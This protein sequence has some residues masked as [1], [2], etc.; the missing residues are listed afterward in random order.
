[1]GNGLSNS[2]LIQTANNTAILR[3]TTDS[4]LGWTIAGLSFQWTTQQTSSN[5]A[6]IAIEFALG[7][8]T[9]YG[10]YNG[11]IRDCRFLYGYRGIAITTSGGVFLPVWETLFD[12][13]WF[14][15][16]AGAAI[17]LVP[18]GNGG[19][20]N[21][22]FRHI[23]VENVSVACA[24]AQVD[25]KSQTGC[26]M[27]SIDLEG[28]TIATASV[29]KLVSSTVSIQNLRIENVNITQ[30]SPTLIYVSDNPVS[31]HGLQ[32][33]SATNTI[34]LV[35]GKFAIV[36]AD[37]NAQVTLSGVNVAATTNGAGVLIK[38]T[39]GAQARILGGIQLGASILPYDNATYAGSAQA[40]RTDKIKSVQSITGWGAIATGGGFAG[41]N[42]TVTGARVGDNVQATATLAT[43]LPFGALVWPLVTGN[44]TIR[45]TIF[46]FGSM[47]TPADDT[48]TIEVGNGQ[49]PSATI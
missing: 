6:S 22:T 16:M 24:E 18:S 2:A 29:L 42:V 27:Q 30:A 26:A 31:I 8:T 17:S 19:M 35:S 40:T 4:T 5:T 7:V 23:F 39:S 41:K 21:N 28:A 49:T 37:S 38:E 32:M 13:L 14:G 46:N 34:N 25:L 11:T 12:R 47:Y 10:F 45:I 44:D 43:T 48:W 36:H 15:S 33:P 20:A 3:F 9:A 1:M